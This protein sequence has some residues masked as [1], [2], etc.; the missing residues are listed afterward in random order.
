MQI[1]RLLDDRELIG[2]LHPHFVDLH[3]ILCG[4]SVD[5][6]SLYTQRWKSGE[7]YSDRKKTAESLCA[8]G[9]LGLDASD[10]LYSCQSAMIWDQ[11]K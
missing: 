2:T 4:R 8:A 5:E 11:H 1:E 6:P 10:N 7:A 9:V 3:F